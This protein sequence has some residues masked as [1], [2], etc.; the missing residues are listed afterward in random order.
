MTGSTLPVSHAR[1]R[2]RVCQLRA[3]PLLPENVFARIRRDMVVSHCKW[4][5]QVGD[6]AALCDFPLLISSYTWRH[7][8]R[9]A[10]R[11]AAETLELEEALL[12]QPELIAEL[13]LPARLQ[14]VFTRGEAL[15]PTLARVMRFDFHPTAQGWRISEVNADVPGGFCEASAFTQLVGDHFGLQTCGNPAGRLVQ[16]LAQLLAQRL[17]RATTGP[18]GIFVAPG[19]MEDW[20][21]GSYLCQAFAAHG[22][23]ARLGVLRELSWQAGRAHLR[24]EALSSVYR[25]FQGEWLA[26][27]ANWRAGR[28]LLAGGATP[29]ANGPAAVLSESKRLPL[30]WKPFGARVPTWTEFLPETRE[31]HA[32][33]WWREDDWLLKGAYS[34]NGDA[35]LRARQMT[36]RRRWL[37]RLEA[38][39][40]RRAWV[41]Q[42]RFEVQP[43]WCPKG[44][45]WRPCL[46][47]YVIEGRAVGVYGRVSRSEIVDY[48]ARD[49]AVL[50]DTA[51]EEEFQQ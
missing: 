40:S 32:V 17:A 23:A 4:D 45:P 37:A 12:A 35:V 20:Q 7:L 48:A 9:T 46:G 24:G 39:L 8:A 5:P 16:L 6:D 34:N 49:V 11:L 50:I 42:K 41:A 30:L 47:V 25:F 1:D 51:S 3:G 28:P 38:Q 31:P 2:E 26:T 33:D 14:R 18:I 43:V 21:V 36:P 27:R 19:Y 13:G 15:T 29:V 10:E 22:L 44:Q